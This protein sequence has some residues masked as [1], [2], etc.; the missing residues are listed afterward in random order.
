[1][2]NLNLDVVIEKVPRHRFEIEGEAFMIAHDKE[3]PKTIQ[4]S[5]SGPTSKEWNKAMEKEINS[6]KYSQV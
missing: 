2:N 3:E 6:M 1:M 5:L 4:E